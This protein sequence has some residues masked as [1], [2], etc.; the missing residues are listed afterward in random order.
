M[1]VS[2]YYAA[3]FEIPEDYYLYNYSDAELKDILF[4][5]DEWNEFDYEAAKKILQ[6]RVENVSE[7]ELQRLHEARL[8]SLKDEYEN[9]KEVKLILFSNIS[10]PLP[11]VFFP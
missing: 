5:R 3:R 4:K 1:L 8:A 9:P 6:E 11:D 10:S 2:G 7:H